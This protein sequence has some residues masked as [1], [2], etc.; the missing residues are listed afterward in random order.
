MKTTPRRRSGGVA[1]TVALSL[2]V[3]LG[4]AA[5][6]VDLGYA[7]LVQSQLQTAADASAMAGAPKLDGR[8]VGLD[9]AREYARVLGQANE[10]NGAPVMLDI[11]PTNRPEGDIVLGVWGRDTGAFTPSTDPAKVN[12]VQVVARNQALLPLFSRAAFGVNRLGAEAR[13]VAVRRWMGAGSVPWYLPFGLP[14]CVFETLPRDTIQDM[15]FLLN[16]AGMDNT[17]WITV[18]GS[19]TASW[20]RDHIEAILPCMIAWATTGEAPAAC[21]AAEVGA[22]SGLANGEDQ[23]GLKAIAEAL[24]SSGLPWDTD[25]WGP[26]PDQHPG[27]D[28]SPYGNMLLGPIPIFDGG[29]SYCAPGG[30]AWNGHAPVVGFA[31]GALYDVRWS[32]KANQRNIWLRL[33]IESFYHLSDSWGGV[34]YGVVAPGPAELVQ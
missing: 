26:L 33:D 2:L 12:A 31:M 7:R 25:P 22:T 5:L 23:S 3:L 24:G 21:A 13:A 32:T 27:S 11:N 28:V 1:L 14:L 4:F 8:L 34:N 17:G 6:V 10:A 18:G 20:I 9:N 16:P 19:P 30:G 29:A 15:E